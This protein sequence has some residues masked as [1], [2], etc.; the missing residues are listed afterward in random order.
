MSDATAEQPTP[1]S[2]APAAW[3][4]GDIN[5]SILTTPTPPNPPR[6]GPATGWFGDVNTTRAQHRNAEK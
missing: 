6:P 5:V 1:S 3:P 4:A 2:S